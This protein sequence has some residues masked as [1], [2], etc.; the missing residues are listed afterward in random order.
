MRKGRAF[1]ANIK[2]PQRPH[3]SYEDKC[4]NLLIVR[5]QTLKNETYIKQKLYIFEV[6]VLHIKLSVYSCKVRKIS[7]S[8]LNILR[9][10]D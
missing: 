9:E 8:T 2:C 7:Q 4:R 1:N 10:K 6:L 5:Q 3:S